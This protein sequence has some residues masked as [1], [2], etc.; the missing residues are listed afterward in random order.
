MQLDLFKNAPVDLSE[1]ANKLLKS[2][3]EDL[4]PKE[5]YRPM[6]YKQFNDVVLLVSQNHE[7]D[8]LFNIIDIDGN[9]PDGMSVCW[10]CAAL[11]KEELIEYLKI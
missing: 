8:T 4:N 3:N 5:Q 11:A 7:K 10:R 2:L 9:A 6:Y 1:K